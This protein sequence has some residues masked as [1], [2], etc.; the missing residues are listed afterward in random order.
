MTRYAESAL[1]AQSQTQRWWPV[2]VASS[3]Y[4]FGSP[5][6]MP[7]T[8]PLPFVVS[9]PLPLITPD[10]GGADS[11]EDEDSSDEGVVAATL[12]A[13][14]QILAV[15]SAEHVASFLTSGDSRMRVMYSL[16]ALKCVTGT[17]WVRSYVVSSC[18]TKTLPCESVYTVRI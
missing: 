13:T 14:S 2:S 11:D 17:S 10:V 3:G 5:M 16:C 12:A 15:W 6:P 4:G 1:K 18:Q 7:P 9:G 8:L